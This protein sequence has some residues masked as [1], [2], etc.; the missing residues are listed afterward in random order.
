MLAIYASAMVMSSLNLSPSI[1]PTG[2]KTSTNENDH[3][4][5]INN[6]VRESTLKDTIVLRNLYNNNS[7]CR[8]VYINPDGYACV[9][10]DDGGGFLIQAT[11]Q[12]FCNHSLT[13]GKTLERIVDE[14]R[15]KT[16]SLGHN[17][18]TMEKIED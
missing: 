15:S 6:G 13:Y 8:F 14:I 16:T 18:S 9:D 17:N 12:V 4:N 10:A 2:T 11:K 5:K 1:S 7:N 3:N